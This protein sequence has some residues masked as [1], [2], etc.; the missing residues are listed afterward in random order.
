MLRKA[1][2]V[3]KE[4]RRKAVPTPS[5]LGNS[6]PASPIELPNLDAVTAELARRKLRTFID[7][8]WPL[9][10]PTAKFVPNWHIDVLC[11]ALEGVTR[12]D[13]KR[14]IINIPPGTMKSLLVSVI[15]PAW[16]WASSPSLRH[17][18]FSYGS[19]LTI[20]DNLRL[21]SIINSSWYQRNFALC[22]KG[23]QNE[24]VRFNT[25]QGGWRVAS[26]VGGVGT[27]EHP[28]RIIIDDP[29][30]ADQARSEIERTNVN[31]WFGSTVS[32]RGI[33]RDV[34]IVVIMQ[35]LHQEDLSGHLLAQGG[36]D[37]IRWPMRYERNPPKGLKPDK[38]DRRREEGELLYP[39]LFPE[40]TVRTL[41]LNLGPYGTAGQLQQRPA[42]EGGGLFKREWFK[43][44]DVPPVMAQRVRGWDTAATE[45]A[46][47]YTV[48]VRISRIGTDFFVE[49]V[50]RGQL[51]PHGVDKLMLSAAAMDGI[52]C[53]QREER[54]GGASGK[55]VVDV[56]AKTLLGYD[57]RASTISINKV[58][59]AGPFRSQVEAGNVYLVRA[60]WN[61]DYIEEMCVFPTGKHDDQVDASSCSFNA[62]VLEPV[63][64]ITL[65]PPPL[66]PHK[67]V[68]DVG[69]GEVINPALSY[70]N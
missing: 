56:R 38:L 60:A 30:T 44:V 51:S 9:V 18:T 41:E 35:R 20:R 50:V 57:Y 29:L 24:K 26:S 48:G 52:S 67:S 12:G 37:H 66:M 63:V 4:A 49:D 69:A 32:S 47:D 5:P 10:E 21:R 22:M 45:G 68:W 58:S 43:F 17:L 7:C 39:T 3:T 59:R 34:R 31:S 46:G 36:W 28:D 14:L 19:H 23:D 61:S 11:D 62:L 27:G 15:W 25:A 1:A 13:T 16:E 2:R 33:S 65:A 53:K 64:T 55:A 54:E 8:V 70:D 42:P 6:R 40:S